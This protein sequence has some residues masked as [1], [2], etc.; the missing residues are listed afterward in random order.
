MKEHQTSTGGNG[1]KDDQKNTLNNNDDCY[2]NNDN[3]LMN[4]DDIYD[5]DID[6]YDHYDSVSIQGFVEEA[7][8]PQV[9]RKV[10]ISSD[11]SAASDIS[12]LVSVAKSVSIAT[13]NGK[14]VPSSNTNKNTNA[15]LNVSRDNY[16][17]INKND[18][19]INN[20]SSSSNNN[21]YDDQSL[22]LSRPT[23]SRK[24]LL[25]NKQ[26]ILDSVPSLKSSPK[27]SPA[28]SPRFKTSQPVQNNRT[29]NNNSNSNS[30]NNG[31]NNE[32]E[33]GMFKIQHHTYSK[34]TKSN[35]KYSP[36]NLLNDDYDNIHDNNS[37]SDFDN[38]DSRSQI[39][40]RD[41][42]NT[43]YDEND[44]DDINNDNNDN[45]DD[46]DF[47]NEFSDGLQNLGDTATIH[48]TV[49]LLRAHKLAISE[50]VEVRTLYTMFLNYYYYY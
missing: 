13:K 16:S 42:S 30:N 41:R 18:K 46:D 29:N 38:Y 4:P 40:Y 35:T 34:P 39:E 44:D 33:L 6:N 14:K 19:S 27:P 45:D 22:D 28:P 23:G 47:D 9:R 12:S 50:M 31:Y 25:R 32:N 3:N 1:N 17:N 37:V 21:S 43:N 7:S 49:G 10:S 2:Y 8:S 20:N 26:S 48:K 15:S 36:N 11:I 5:S 24:L